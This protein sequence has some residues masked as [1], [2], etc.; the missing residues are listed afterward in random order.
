M[1]STDDGDSPDETEYGLVMPFV[2]C[3]DNGPFDARSFVAGYRMAELAYKIA[4][5]SGDVIESYEHPDLV[6]QIDLFA[7]QHGWTMTLEPWVDHPDEWVAVT[8]HREAKP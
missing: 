1:T 4:N 2:V 3:G 6:P 8:L 5:E 7:M